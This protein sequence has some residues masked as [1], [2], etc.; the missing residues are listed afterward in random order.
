MKIKT[1]SWLELKRQHLPITTNLLD[2]TSR[3]A[4]INAIPWSRNRCAKNARGGFRKKPSLPPTA[5]SRLCRNFQRGAQKTLS[6][7]ATITIFKD[8]LLLH[9]PLAI[10]FNRVK[11]A[12]KV[13]I[14]QPF[15]LESN[16]CLVKLR[17]RAK[18][19]K[20]LVIKQLLA[21]LKLQN[22]K[23]T[24]SSFD[25]MNTSYGMS[26]STLSENADTLTKDGTRDSWRIPLQEAI[27]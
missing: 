5:R 6:P 11:A 25:F 16:N 22:Y 19:F 8:L 24:T 12:W 18:L 26:C 17:P 27:H 4:W 15:I 1:I 3:A 9:P 7:A 2:I 20:I 21:F 13:P 10:Y 23:R 14:S